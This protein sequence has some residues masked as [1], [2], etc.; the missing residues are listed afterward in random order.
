MAKEIDNPGSTFTQVLEAAAKLP[1]VRINRE[2]YLRA[3][4]KRYCSAEQLERAIAES[5]AAAG[6]PL[7]VI[8]SVA[9]TAITFETSPS[10]MGGPKWT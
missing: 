2:T 9:N 5:P 3:A 1:G 6:I 10:Q 4:L 8:T 7:T